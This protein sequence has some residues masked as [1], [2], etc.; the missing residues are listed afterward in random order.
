MGL[1]KQPTFT[2]EPNM[3]LYDALVVVAMIAAI[4]ATFFIVVAV[5]SDVVWPWLATVWRRHGA[6]KPQARRIR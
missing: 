1:S 3:S 2:E 4:L 6:P 5:I